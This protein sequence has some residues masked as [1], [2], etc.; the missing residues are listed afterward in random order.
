MHQLNALTGHPEKLE[1]QFMVVLN[2]LL[3][4]HRY[5]IF[6]PR[7]AISKFHFVKLG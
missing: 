4:K 6:P 2:T 7:G 1:V 3:C 5:L